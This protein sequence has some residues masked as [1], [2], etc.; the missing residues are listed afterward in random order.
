M[1][2]CTTQIGLTSA[3]SGG[4]DPI[5][6][7]ATWT[8]GA[9]LHSQPVNQPYPGTPTTITL[10]D[11]TSVSM[12]A[13]SSGFN[14]QTL[15]VTCGQYTQFELTQPGSGGGGGGG[16]GGCFI[17]S[18]YYGTAAAPEVEFLQ[19]FRDNVLRRT[20][21][22]KQFFEDLWRYYYRISPPIAEEMNRDPEM[23][24]VVGWA[25]VEPWVN[26][27]KLM[28]RR[29]DFKGMNLEGLDPELRAFLLQ[30]QTDSD[31]WTK[32]IELP[33]SFKDRDPEEAVHEL[34][35]VLGLVLLRADGK[36]YLEDLKSRGELPLKCP[37][38]DEPK[39]QGIL[40]MAGRTQDEITAILD[41]V[42]P[43]HPA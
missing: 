43:P 24:R 23:R 10:T 41:G 20:R 9:G 18:A 16:R 27:M 37:K 6:G 42:A 40:A 2:T 3:A 7:T 25:I 22:G 1:P 17:A 21:W 28:I 8:D 26:Y 38:E 19:G 29:P 39:L 32:G 31:K 35:I 13:S 14:S 11:V 5:S 33:K 12:T 30:L 4:A 15:T 36:A 34:N